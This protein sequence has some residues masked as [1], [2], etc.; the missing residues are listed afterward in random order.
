[1][2]LKLLIVLTFSI[3]SVFAQNFFPLNNGNKYQ[4]KYLDEL[5][6]TLN[7]YTTIKYTYPFSTISDSSIIDGNVYYKYK[8]Y[9]PDPY[10]PYEYSY[11]YFDSL[12]QKLFVD[13][14]GSPKVA[15]DFNLPNGV[16]KVLYFQ[17]IPSTWRSFGKSYKTVLGQNRLVYTLDFDTVFFNSPRNE[18]TTRLHFAE[19]VGLY[20]SRYWHWIS[21][22]TYHWYYTD[23]YTLLA[24]K[25]SNNEYRVN[26]GIMLLD[27]VTNR[28]ITD[29]PYPLAVDIQSSIPAL[30]K[31]IYADFYIYRNDSLTLQKR[32]SI[33]TENN[34]GFINIQ[35]E[36]LQIGDRIEFT[37]SLLDSSIFNNY[38]TIPDSGRFS[39]LVL[40]DPSTVKSEGSLSMK[41]SLEQNYPNPFNSATKIKYSIPSAED[42]QP[43]LV[44]LK[45]F[46][47]LGRE[48]KT[49]V[50]KFQNN[51]KYEVD[52]D[53]SGLPSGVYY[54]RLS[55]GVLNSTKKLIHLK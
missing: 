54:Y 25:I 51:G 26:T 46:D 13:L 17:G 42:Y 24:A 10:A 41:F 55:A 37:C 39:Y 32:F 21:E 29:F 9:N 38:I 20:Y 4:V 12:T 52:F 33:D 48:I 45:V 53:A 40:A 3:G 27:S 47:L 35:Q 28:K 11:Y 18:I 6:L 5:Y 49:L 36:E 15:V 30:V 19:G 7:D 8:N 43:I 16:S 44:S 34:L 2:K 22:I 31:E 1:M 50:N 14:N 23:E